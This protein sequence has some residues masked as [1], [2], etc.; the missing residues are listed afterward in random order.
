MGKP[1]TKTEP[2]F[3]AARINAR[4]TPEKMQAMYDSKFPVY[5]AKFI[6]AGMCGYQ[7][8]KDITYLSADVLYRMA[9]TFVGRPVVLGHDLN[10]TNDNLEEKAKGVVLEC[11]T[12][13]GETWYVKFA[14]TDEKLAKK[15]DA[16]GFNFVSCAYIITEFGE[17]EVHDGIEC[18]TVVNNAFYHHLAIT[19][20]PRYD[21]SRS[22]RINENDDAN[23]LYKIQFSD[24]IKM[25][26]KV[27]TV[28]LNAWT[29]QE[30]TDDVLFETDAGEMTQSQMVDKI[31][32]LNRDLENKKSELAKKEDDLNTLKAQIKE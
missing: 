3:I 20:S 10:I 24:I 9:Q 19:N 21:D 25:N 32:E 6:H 28:K 17:P 13:D 2:E 1:F 15:I 31:N 12:Y 27:A 14:I 22:F 18:T 8:Q 5:E 30:I 26:E 11:Q 23:G 16:D 7:E 4:L 29:K